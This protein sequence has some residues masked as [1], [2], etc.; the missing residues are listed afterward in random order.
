MRFGKFDFYKT[1]DLTMDE[2]QSLFQECMELSYD[3]RADTLDCSVS[4]SRQRFNCSFEEILGYLKENTHVAVI[5]RGTWGSLFGESREHFEI[6]FR[7]MDSPVD[8]FLFIQVDSARMPP[9]L[10]KY[11]LVPIA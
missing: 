9:I 11:Q 8:Y 3:W 6:A 4:W 2:K 10:E 1:D 7:T 5:N